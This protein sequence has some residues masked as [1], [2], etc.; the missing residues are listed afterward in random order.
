MVH[1]AIGEA[2]AAATVCGELPNEGGRA[3]VQAGDAGE[4][5]LVIPPVYAV[6]AAEDEAV[7]VGGPAAGA[8][9]KG[10]LVFAEVAGGHRLRPEP[11]VEA[12]TVLGRPGRER[13]LAEWV[14][15]ADVLVAMGGFR[16]EDG[17]VLLE[18]RVAGEALHPCQVA[19]H[20]H[21]QPVEVL[22]VAGADADTDAVSGPHHVGQPRA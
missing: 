5:V 16:V 3:P 12:A 1:K 10:E 22:G 14:V 20:V 17:G 8:G 9:T 6:S 2:R 19:D 15:M 18:L 4:D 11:D 13:G 21:G 7:H